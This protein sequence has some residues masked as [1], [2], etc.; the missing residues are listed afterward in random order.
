MPLPPTAEL[1]Q[2]A[3]SGLEHQHANLGRRIAEIR[4]QLGAAPKLV[5]H[6]VKNTSG[7]KRPPMSAEAK[8]RIAAGQRKRWKKYH[9]A[10]K[11][12]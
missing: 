3:L 6:P 10:M 4:A 1:L 7:R 8:K 12:Q 11:H 5:L 9:E 2:A